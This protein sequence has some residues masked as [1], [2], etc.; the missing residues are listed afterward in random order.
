[1]NS[2]EEMRQYLWDLL[3]HESACEK[4]NC[5]V[6]RAALATYQL[7]RERIFAGHVYPGVAI[8]ARF[9]ARIGRKG[10]SFTAATR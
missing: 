8:G 10:R 1:M 5:A 7:I 6:C 9:G 3:D 4:E 2:D